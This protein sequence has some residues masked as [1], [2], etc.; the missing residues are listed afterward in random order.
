MVNTAN[1]RTEWPLCIL[2]GLPKAG[3]GRDERDGYPGSAKM[4][5]LVWSAWAD[6][7]DAGAV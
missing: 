3:L 2:S 5:A 6:W 7:K 4:S 1:T